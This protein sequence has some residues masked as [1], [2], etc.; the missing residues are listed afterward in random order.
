MEQEFE[1]KD[2]RYKHNLCGTRIHSIHRDMLAR[3]NNPNRPRYKDYGARGI[4][5]CE[6]WSGKNGLLHFHKW[7]MEN[8]YS[9]ELTI[10][11]IDN[12]GNYCPQNCRWISR[13]A[14]GN[15]TR[16]N[17][18]ITLDGETH[19][20]A[21][22]CAIKGYLYTRIYQRIHSLNWSYERALSHE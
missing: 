10:D 9:D 2:K 7:A 3:C 11:R 14:Q 8:G 15:N 6:E 20:L 16:R 5:V 18:Y 4:K 12:N 13:D 17:I 21:E 1:G 22:W 19:T